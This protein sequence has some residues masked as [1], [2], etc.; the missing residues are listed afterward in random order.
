MSAMPLLP[1]WPS[2]P[3]R[4]WWRL[5]LLPTG[6]PMPASWRLLSCF[7]MREAESNLRSRR[8]VH[9]CLHSPNF[10]QVSRAR[11]KY[12]SLAEV[13]VFSV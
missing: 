2:L 1:R 8:R 3:P 7:R 11:N 4:L 13:I 12:G 9:S 10:C 5:G 6:S